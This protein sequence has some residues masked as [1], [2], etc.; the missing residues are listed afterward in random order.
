MANYSENPILSSDVNWNEEDPANGLLWSGKSIREFQQKK[1]KETEINTATKVGALHFDAST[2]TLYQF[3]SEEAKELWLSN[4][5]EGL[6]LGVVPFNFTGTLNQIKIINNLGSTNLYY[7]TES[8]AVVLSVAFLSQQK[9]ITDVSWSD[10]N[11]DFRVSVSVDRG[12]NGIYETI[13]SDH[14]LLNGKLFTVDVKKYLANGANR[15]KISVKG[16]DTGISKSLVLTV[17]ITSM[18]IRPANFTWNTPFI[19][20]NIYPIG[21]MNIGGNLQKLLKVKVKGNN[22]EKNYTVNIGSSTYINTAYY[23]SGMEFPS[24]GSGIYNIELWLDANGLESEHLSYNIICV[25]KADV[26]TAQFVALNEMSDSVPNGI[27]K[28]IFAYTLYNKGEQQSDITVQV[29]ID[30]RLLVDETLY[31]V[32]TGSKVYYT[33]AVEYESEADNLEVDVT[34]TNGNTVNIKKPLDNS[35]LYPA[36]KGATLYINESRRNNTQANKEKFI[37]EATGEE[38]NAVWENFIFDTDAHATDDTGRKC[39]NVPAGS[40]VTIAAQPLAKWGREGSKTIEFAFKASNVSNYNENIITI[41]NA[42]GKGIQIKPKNVLVLM[43]GTANNNTLQS[44]NLKDE[45]YVHLL[46]TIVKG[47]QNYGN[48][49]QIY[50]NGVKTTSFDFGSENF[51]VSANIVIGSSSADTYLYKLRVYEQ[52]FEW[53]AVTDNVA[54]SLPTHEEK[55]AYINNVKSILDTNYNVD[56]DAVY[57]K[58]NTFVVEMIDGASFPDKLHPAGGKCNTWINIVDRI[59]DELDEEF[60]QLFSG[61]LIANQEIEGQGTTAMTYLRWNTRQKLGAEYGKRR[62]T[63][64][65]NVASSMHS[66]KM[67][68]TRMFNE[69]H[70]AI[71]GANEGNGRVAV[72]QYPVYGFQKFTEG[73]TTTYQFIGLYTIGPDKGDKKTFGYDKYEESIIHLEGADH[74]PLG[75]GFD[76]PWSELKYSSAKESLGAVNTKGETV[77]AW[78]VGAVGKLSTDNESDEAA[79]K[80]VLNTEFRPA[81][82][83]VYNSSTFI[84]GITSEEYTEM[85]ADP[86]AWRKKETVDGKS[87]SE[88]EFYV[89]GEYDLYYYNLQ[90]GNYKKNGI[91]LLAQTGVTFTSETLAQKDEKF[92]AWRKTHFKNN[93]QKYWHLQDALF[94]DALLILIGASDNFKKNNYPYKFKSLADGGLW[95]RRQDDLD[96]IFDILNQGFAGKSYSVLFGDKNSGGSIFRG[97]NSVFHT[98]IQECYP[99]EFKKMMHKILDKMSSFSP[100]GQGSIER[101]VGYI[102]SRFWDYAQ[103]YF[104]SSAYNKDAEWTYEEAWKLWG[105]QYTGAD[106]HPLQQ[107]LGAHYEAERDWVT[108]RMLFVASYYNWGIFSSGSTDTSEG[109]LTYRTASGKTFTITPAIDFNPTILVG[110]SEV[111][112]AGRRINAG[113]HATVIVR[114]VGANDTHVY[115]QGL[116]WIAD[117]GDLSDLQLDANNPELLIASKRLKSL[118]LGGESTVTSN[119]GKLS[120]GSMPSLEVIDA[121]N[122]ANLSGAINLQG[123]PRL[124][125]ALFA[126]TNISSIYLADGSR[127][128]TLQTSDKMSQLVLKNLP[129]LTDEGFEFTDGT[130]VEYLRIENCKHI[131]AFEL[132]KQL[133]NLDSKKLTSIRVVN[134]N[135]VGTREDV[136]ILINLANNIDKDGNYK[137][138]NGIDANGNIIPDAEGRNSVPVIEGRIEIP[139]ALYSDDIAIINNMYEG[140]LAII[141]TTG[142]YYVKFADPEVQRICVENWGDGTGITLEQI[143]SISNIDKT[144][145]NNTLIETFDELGKFTSLTSLKPTA[146]KGCTNLKS[147]DISNITVF[148]S[149][150]QNGPFEDTALE[151]VTLA[152]G[153][154]ETG[155][156]PFMNCSKLK[157]VKLP[158]TLIYLGTTE[159]AYGSGVFYGT[160]I[161]DIELPAQLQRIGSNVFFKCPL[162]SIKCP[163]TVTYIG[164]NAFLRCPSLKEVYM[165]ENITEIKASVFEYCTALRTVIITTVVPPTAGNNIFRGLTNFNIYV[166][167]ESVNAYKEATNWVSYANQ[168]KPINVVS[169]RPGIEKVSEGDLYKVGNIYWK[170][171]NGQDLLEWVEIFNLG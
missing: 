106:V 7:T 85:T 107:S 57:G 136:T 122:L 135:Y 165:G 60:K 101:L 29:G 109:Q 4:N 74:T 27:E 134:F 105:T 137:E 126:G 149:E 49:C 140:K 138:Y 26:A 11:E 120:I 20:G 24:M 97:E 171:A 3:A 13:I 14:L 164:Q 118:K 110:D 127:I 9:S 131:N 123:C 169:V 32:S 64:K 22:Y 44:Y 89:D 161:E 132:L 145:Y 19:E 65:K 154:T 150:W 102:K 146:F 50:V 67:G 111:N 91:N 53:A 103:E 125:T 152:E 16:V 12:S 117:L 61:E 71:V 77:S 162:K 121:R 62:I 68:A 76:Y 56:Y 92:K 35:A 34:V 151:S 94:H 23:Y 37:N 8:E 45:E 88:L 100:Y 90:E 15:V 95:Q 6:L 70:H 141:S 99:E 5:N 43:S 114:E 83:I 86:I 2:M 158:S 25:S 31:N 42:D 38:I 113:E 157:N 21:G 81:Y 80:A 52:G 160:A 66:H 147:I 155:Q 82:D 116:D 28:N 98:L 18:F 93:M 96:S 166:P 51:I 129:L 46:I 36:T 142:T 54:N 153:M 79:V 128:T 159:Y 170:A 40:K 119:L 87:Y 59:D 41:A 163:N 104:P 55:I 112:S 144:F 63:A 124:K 73:T 1:N 48:L 10:V 115:V 33:A 108:L 168:I 39:L 133:Y 69:L 47:Y 130:T 139:S 156:R 78:E 167:S 75:V 84:K 72:F 143:K 58:R 148:G 30:G 17:N